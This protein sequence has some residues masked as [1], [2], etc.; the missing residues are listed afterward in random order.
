[1]NDNAET[2][3]G[4]TGGQTTTSLQAVASDEVSS[5]TSSSSSWG[6][7]EGATASEEGRHFSFHERNRETFLEEDEESHTTTADHQQQQQQQPRSS[8]QNTPQGTTT[9]S[10]P[11]NNDGTTVPT[12]Q[13]RQ[14]LLLMLLAQ[15]CA[16]H[17]PTPRTFTVHVLELFER[18]LLDR[19]SIHFLFELGLVPSSSPPAHKTTTKLLPP[20][21]TTAPTAVQQQQQDSLELLLPAATQ[22]PP[23]NNTDH[24][25]TLATQRSLEASSIR[26]QLEHLD[27][28]Q[29]QKQRF[30][31]D[32]KNNNNSRLHA[33]EQPQ[34][35]PWSVEAH[36]LSLSRYQ[37][38]F[39]QIKLLATGGFGQVFRATNKMD[40]LDYAIKRVAF[41]AEGYSKDSVQQVVREVHCLAACDHPNVVRYYTS[42]LEPSW[43]TGSSSSSC[44]STTTGASQKLLKDGF[45]QRSDGSEND[46]SDVDLSDY[47]KDPSFSSSTGKHQRRFSSGDSFECSGSIVEGSEY[48]EWSVEGGDY[49]TRDD[50]YISSGRERRQQ[51]IRSELDRELE[52]WQRAAPPPR[53]RSHSAEEKRKYSYQMCLFIQMQLCHPKTLADLIRERNNQRRQDDTIAN[54]IET[55]AKV[56]EQMVAGLAHVHE[57]GIVHRDLKPANCFVDGTKVKIGDFGLSKLIESASHHPDPNSNKNA[58]QYKKLHHLL[59]GSETSPDRRDSSTKSTS[60]K[61]PLTAGVGTASYAAPEQV[62]S[63]QYGTAADVFSLGLILLELLCSFSTEHERLQVFQDCRSRRVLPKELDNYPIAAQTILACTE[64]NPQNRPS[65]AALQGVDMGLTEVHSASSCPTTSAAD[66]TIQSLREELLEKDM[67]LKQ[68]QRELADRDQIIAEL[69]QQLSLNG[70]NCRSDYSSS[71]HSTSED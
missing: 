63:R 34:Q 67:A 62:S 27:Q 41:A 69:R 45:P 66:A 5:S 3:Q 26:M 60:W 50:L 9:T 40:G 47:F 53:Q 22:A 2:V 37:R 13:E 11:N 49:S 7:D 70:N 68:C 12:D 31:H 24:K 14:L 8:S 44:D 4:S 6:Y 42:W 28:Q 59:L 64:R 51:F 21:T 18:G 23:N 30:P 52:A 36:P 54:R 43:M 71:A 65:A 10:A 29:Q 61:D 58:R 1:M 25:H 39:A 16:L 55:A 35:R 48:S 33:A 32:P 19:D 56:F 38:E 20:S 57:K 46:S 17:D 15:V